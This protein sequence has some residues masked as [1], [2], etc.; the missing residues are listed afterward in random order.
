MSF[1]YRALLQQH[2][3]LLRV[4]LTKPV[5]GLTVNLAYG[6]TGIRY[7]SIADYVAAARQPAISRLPAT[8]PSP[9]VSLTFDGWVFP[10]GGVAFVWVLEQEMSDQQIN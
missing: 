1:T 9:S 4:D 5:K 6:G 2:G 3:H 7:V 8:D 10:K